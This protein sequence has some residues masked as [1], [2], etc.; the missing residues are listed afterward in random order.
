MSGVASV[1]WSWVRP[2]RH[3][4][5][6]AQPASPESINTGRG[7]GFRVRAFGAPRNDERLQPDLAEIDAGAEIGFDR[8]LGDSPDGNLD[9]VAAGILVELVEF[10]V[11]VIVAHGVGDR[12][13]VLAEPNA[14]ALDA[15]NAA[16]RLRRKRPA[17]EAFRIA[18]EIA[19]I[20]ARA[21]AQL[22]PHHFEA[23]VARH[24]A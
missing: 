22:G 10:E 12:A 1:I 8:F 23:L 4:G 17:D 2:P 20:D 21:A 13:A 3:S 11:A 24:P 9:E 16:V 5:A 14:R 19:V 6:R 7:Y 18:P 15:I